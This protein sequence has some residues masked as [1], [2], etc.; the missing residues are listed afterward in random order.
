VTLGVDLNY[1]LSIVMEMETG[2]GH[3]KD[4]TNVCGR[5]LP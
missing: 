2:F 1:F 3:A 4:V 5:D